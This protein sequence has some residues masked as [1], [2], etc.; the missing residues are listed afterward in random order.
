MREKLETNAR[1][2]INAKSVDMK[3]F[4]KSLTI[5]AT[6]IQSATASMTS[7]PKPL[8]FLRPFYNDMKKFYSR[9]Q[10][11]N[12]VFRK[13]LADVLSVLAMTMAE[14]GSRD[15]L[16]FKLSGN[17]S[18]LGVWGHEFVRALCG[19]ISQEYATLPSVNEEGEKD[20]SVEQKR[21]ELTELSH[22][23]VPFLIK[24][25]TETEAVDLLFETE[26]LGHLFSQNY[27]DHSNYER[28]CLY[29]TKF[30][31][32]LFELDDLNRV[33]GVTFQLY[34]NCDDLPNALRIALRM[35]DADRIRK[36]FE[37]KYGETSEDDLMMK[38]QLGFIMGSQRNFSYQI[39][40][41]DESAVN[42]CINNTQLS[43]NFEQLA[44][45]LTM[46]E[47]KSPEDVYKSHLAEPSGFNSNVT[48]ESARKNLCATYVNGFVNCGFK[49]DS[50]IEKDTGDGD[51]KDG[52]AVDQNNEELWVFRNKEAGKTAAV[53][54]LGL[55]YLWAGDEIG[56]DVLNP[57]MEDSQTDVHCVSGALLG[58]GV[59]D[60]GVKSP[61]S[62]ALGLISDALQ[63]H[64]QKENRYI[65]I[66]G[67]LGIALAAAG[68]PPEEVEGE[69]EDS[70][71]NCLKNMLENDDD[72]AVRSFAAL[73]IGFMYIGTGNED[74]AADLTGML[75]D[76]GLDFD[77]PVLRF[78]ALGLALIYLGKQ[79][80]AKV[81][82][83]C[84]HFIVNV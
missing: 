44:R 72:V 12:D 8:K 7:V 4:E 26:D 51:G 69:D 13:K 36:V 63:T 5:L 46:E 45:N 50:L 76:E 16:K 3:L 19:E 59:T 33:L 77:E 71:Y 11:V 30:A 79:V 47:P 35:N 60:C 49:K 29:L 53:A 10:K 14:E 43:K 80:C 78:C 62:T 22:D 9:H 61:F 52:M 39:E 67:A 21:H 81:G 1:K 75:F 38:K 34:L 70:A 25:N 82:A 54:S 18:E 32:F 57:W 31:E 66:C 41:E 74:V 65:K 42:E 17:R 24:Q 23:I 48:A 64:P 27:I 2:L 37:T 20:K 73:S 55:V 84:V 28:T 83:F 58:L 40:D 68:D 15:M 56:S 6:E